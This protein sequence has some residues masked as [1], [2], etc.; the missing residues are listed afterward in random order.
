[1]IEI[2]VNT[3]PIEY[4]RSLSAKDLKKVIRDC[5]K[6]E[7]DEFTDRCRVCFEEF[8]A[9]NYDAAEWWSAHALLVRK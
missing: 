3:T 5:K 2:E 4:A 8:L 6:G 9:G 1:M 7:Y